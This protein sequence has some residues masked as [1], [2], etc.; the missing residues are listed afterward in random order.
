VSGG[1]ATGAARRAVGAVIVIAGWG[2]AGCGRTPAA[3]DPA[4]VQ[5]ARVS[6]LWWLYFGVTALVTI[7]VLTAAAL[8]LFRRANERVADPAAVPQALDRRMGRGIVVAA[9]VSLLLL[10]VLLATDFATRRQLAALGGADTLEVSVTGHQW[11]WEF[12]YPDTVASRTVTT[13]TEVHVPVG[14]PVRFALRAADV[15]HSFWVPR[16]GGKRDVIPGHPAELTLRADTAG[17]Y[18]GVCA[19]FCGHQHATMRFVLVA[20]PPDRF[21]RWLVAQRRPAP[22]PVG[23]LEQRGREVF[24]GTTC[25]MCHAVQGTPAMA[26]MGP[27]LTHVGSRIAVA[28]AT[29]PNSTGHLAGWIVDPQGIRPGVHMPQNPL[30]AEDVRALVAYLRSLR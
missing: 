26:R 22:D 1:R 28:S 19:E 14:R 16:L 3:L 10:G 23:A 27:D 18:D 6:G 25:V 29:L 17:V 11:W 5:A 30:G 13:A 15:I 12:E 8:A 20:D 7:A 4:G 21:A 9:A 24:L 2:L